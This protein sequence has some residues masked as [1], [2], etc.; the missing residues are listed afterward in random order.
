MGVQRFGPSFLPGVFV[1]PMTTL[2]ILAYCSDLF[3]SG[4]GTYVN[5]FLLAG[6]FSGVKIS[7]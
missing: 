5:C 4:G 3:I 1:I 2:C 6:F 7:G